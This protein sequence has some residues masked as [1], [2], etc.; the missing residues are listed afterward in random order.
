[1][2]ERLENLRRNNQDE[3]DEVKTLQEWA[4]NVSGQSEE[5]AESFTEPEIRDGAQSRE[6]LCSFAVLPSD[7]P[8]QEKCNPEVI[9][10]SESTD[11]F[12]EIT[13]LVF[14]S[15]NNEDVAVSESESSVVN[16]ENGQS[17]EA[18]E[19]KLSASISDE[20]REKISTAVAAQ[21]KAINDLINSVKFDS[22]S[23]NSEASSVISETTRSHQ[24]ETEIQNIAQECLNSGMIK[25]SAHEGEMVP[26][27]NSRATSVA[28]SHPSV[29]SSEAFSTPWI[30][31]NFTNDS[32]SNSASQLDSLPPQVRPIPQQPSY[33]PPVPQALPESL[34][35][36]QLDLAADRDILEAVPNLD[37][38]SEQVPSTVEIDFT[39]VNGLQ[40]LKKEF[41]DDFEQL[42]SICLRK[43]EFDATRSA[44]FIRQ[45]YLTSKFLAAKMQLQDYN[46]EPENHSLAE[47]VVH[48]NE[49]NEI[50]SAYIE[51]QYH[52]QR[53]VV[54]VS[55]GR[56]EQPNIWENIRR[57]V[58]QNINGRVL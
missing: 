40:Q 18:P 22:L 9:S 36:L 8:E 13:S 3:I 54:N 26:P 32:L 6:T 56:P 12:E 39:P 37:T 42:Y 2:A 23:Q 5:L 30:D 24:T 27:V 48:V 58:N 11:S 55:N 43:F 31:S 1:M 52:E 28:S 21:A 46:I 20:D 29:Q 57:F 49:I 34:D 38:A 51:H 14:Q 44:E 33:V 15:E 10:V 53:T 47:M 4:A 19:R 17:D 45:N 25:R 50:I 7:I 41:G 35:H 16:I